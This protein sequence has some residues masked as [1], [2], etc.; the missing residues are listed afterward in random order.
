MLNISTNSSSVLSKMAP[1]LNDDYFISALRSNVQVSLISS[2]KCS[3][4]TPEALA[5]NYS[6]GLEVAEKLWK[7]PP[8]GGV[9]LWLLSLYSG[10]SGRA[11]VG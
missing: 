10:D 6:I 1:I 9:E 11:S 5:Q 2:K 8:R 4:V 7:Q 3:G